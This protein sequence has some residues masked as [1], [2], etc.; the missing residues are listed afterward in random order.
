MVQQAFSLKQRAL[1][2]RFLPIS[3]FSCKGQIGS[4]DRAIYV[5]LKGALETY[6]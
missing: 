2:L 3:P 6:Y 5:N 4:F 1:P